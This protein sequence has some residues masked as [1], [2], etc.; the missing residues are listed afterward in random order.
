MTRLL[1]I[2]QVSQP[3]HSS[4]WIIH[5][6]MPSESPMMV[7]WWLDNCRLIQVNNQKPKPSSID[8]SSE[9]VARLSVHEHVTLRMGPGLMTWVSVVIWP[10]LFS[11]WSIFGERLHGLLLRPLRFG[12][13]RHWRRLVSY[14]VRAHVTLHALAAFFEVE[15][16][17][18]YPVAYLRY[19]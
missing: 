6:Y 17:T 8:T 1:T 9:A 13:V 14:A 2:C 15:E 10:T 16:F 18:I 7:G 3:G 5:I 12:W 11:L 19:A 4:I